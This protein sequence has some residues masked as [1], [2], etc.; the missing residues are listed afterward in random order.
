M[1]LWIWWGGHFLPFKN[2]FFLNDGFLN[3]TNNVNSYGSAKKEDNLFTLSNEITPIKVLAKEACRPNLQ[4]ELEYGVSKSG[5]GHET[6][7]SEAQNASQSSPPSNQGGLVR[8][9]PYGGA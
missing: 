8:L 2:S 6:E 7:I 5:Y 3:Y 4:A 9:P 1:Y